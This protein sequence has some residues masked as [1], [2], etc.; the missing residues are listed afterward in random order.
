M[1]S[2]KRT[3]TANRTVQVLI[4][5]D[6]ETFRVRKLESQTYKLEGHAATKH[7]AGYTRHRNGAV[8]GRT[9]DQEA[10]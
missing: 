6:L 10:Q 9:P 4:L 2:G 3:Q 1:E 5:T 7:A 8:T